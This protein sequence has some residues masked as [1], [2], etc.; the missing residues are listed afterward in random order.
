MAR[1]PP[2]LPMEAFLWASHFRLGHDLRPGRSPWSLT[3]RFREDFPPRWGSFRPP[4]ARL[5]PS[6]DVLNQD[7][8]PRWDPRSE[9]TLSF[10]PRPLEPRPE[11]R[12]TDT[13]PWMHRDPSALPIPPSLTHQSYPCPPTVSVPRRKVDKWEDNL[14]RGDPDKLPLPPSLTR[15]AF[16]GHAGV[17]RPDKAPSAH[18]G[19]DAALRGDSR[20]YYETSYKSQYTGKGGAPAQPYKEI[21]DSIPFGDPHCH[22]MESEQKQ[23]FAPWPPSSQRYDRMEAVAKVFQTNVQPGD[24]RRSFSTISSGVYTWKNPDP[25]FVHDVEQNKSSI[26]Q[27]DLEPGR[28]PEPIS[29]YQFYFQTPK[30]EAPGPPLFAA[31]EKPLP[32][33]LG[34]PRLPASFATTHNSNYVP[35]ADEAHKAPSAQ[36]DLLHSNI[37]FNY[38]PPRAPTT[39]TQDMLVPHPVKKHR[40]S[41]EELERLQ[42]T[43]LV[44]PWRGQRWFSTETKD[45]FWNKYSG[46]IVLASGDFQKSSLPLG[47]MDDYLPRPKRPA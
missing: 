36:G 21:M 40:L 24:G 27:G 18:L 25:V 38:Y 19:E 10:P 26:R 29:S 7:M 12:L 35:P 4:P 9:A 23:A 6:V 31:P 14:P 30:E 1:V 2:P 44:Y 28:N 15:E 8:G 41:Q 47:T 13:R 17:T 3:S 32:L 16:R 39:S 5:P 46:P 33:S 37:P 22:D 11:I 42:G 20:Y 43:H 45:R 34:D